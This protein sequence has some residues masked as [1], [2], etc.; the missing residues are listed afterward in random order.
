MYSFDKNDILDARCAINDELAK[1]SNWLIAN[2]IS[3]N[4]S[5]TKYIIF[6]ISNHYV[7]PGVKLGDGKISG[8]SSTKFL[9]VL[10]DNN[11]NFNEHINYI[12]SKISKCNGILYRTKYYF[13][14]NTM[15]HIYN[16][17]FLPYIQY[18]IQAWGNSSV[19]NINK[20]IILQKR[21][22]RNINNLSYLDHTAI[23]FKNNKILDI[24]KLFI[25]VTSIYTFK[26]IKYSY[27]TELFA[28]LTFFNSIHT[29]NTRGRCNLVLPQY[30]RS[31][32]RN[33][34]VFQASYIYNGLPES[35][36]SSVSLSAFKTGLKHY[37]FFE[38][39]N[40]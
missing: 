25:Y 6:S 33:N 24:R 13:P 22:V 38:Y 34:I 31:R 23:Y 35:V 36:R 37:L 28:Q 26:T 17:L 20:L 9:G 21:A 19:N 32:C 4:I 7:M 18:G 27:D 12:A 1:I 40:D 39:D 11:L 16:S 2:K 5:K 29:Y 15:L 3:V 14:H 8:T 10:L 30:N